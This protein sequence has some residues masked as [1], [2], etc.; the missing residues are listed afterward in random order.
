MDVV[1]LMRILFF[2]LFLF[3]SNVNAQIHGKISGEDGLALPYANVLIDHTT[4]GTVSNSE[5]YYYLDLPPGKY[6]L[7]F[8]YIGYKS[9]FREVLMTGQQL[10]LDVILLQESITLDEVTIRA[11]AEDPA[12]AII[13]NAI[14]ARSFNAAGLQ[15]FKGDLYMKG[16]VKMLDAP[17]SFMGIKIG[18]MEGLLDSTRSGIVYLSESESDVY[19]QAPDK[20]KEI[21]KSGVVAGEDNGFSFNQYGSVRFDFYRQHL[22]FERS[23]MTPLHD[24]ALSHYR[25]Q[26]MGT[27]YDEKGRQINKIAV[28]PINDAAGLFSGY[29]YIM[30]DS[31]RIYSLDLR[32]SGKAMKNRVFDFIRIRQIMNEDES[33]GIWY[34]QSQIVDFEAGFFSFRVGGT[35]SFFFREISLNIELPPSTFTREVFSM[36]N[37]AMKLSLTYWDSIRPIPLTHEEKKDYS[38]KDSLKVLKSSRQYMDSVDRANNHWKWSSL[39][40]GYSHHTTYKSRIIRMASPVSSLRFNAVEGWALG[41]RFTY[42]QFLREDSHRIQLSGLWRYGFTDRRWKYRIDGNYLIDRKSL[43]WITTGWGRDYFQFDERGLMPLV[44]NTISS[45][46]YKRNFVKLFDK[47]YAFAGVQ[48]ELWNGLYAWTKLSVEDRYPLENNTEWSFFR[49]DR[50]YESNHPVIPISELPV[51]HSHQAYLLDINFRWRPGQKYMSFPGFRVRMES[52][53]PEFF[54]NY[55]KA[56]PLS[57]NSMDYDRI[58]FRLRHR[59]IN[60]KTWGYSTLNFETG[61]FINNRQYEFPD[62]FHFIGGESFL[63]FH[64]RYI[65]GFK[66]MPF[67]QFS[68]DQSY[69]SFVFE[70]HFDGFILDKIPGLKNSGLKTVVGT[71][72]LLTWEKQYYEVSLGFENVGIGPLAMFRLDYGVGFGPNGSIFHG[73]RLGLSRSLSN[74]ID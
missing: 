37:D 21:M 47:K 2:L 41:S 42:T 64:D 33:S 50:R 59:N 6:T 67:Y 38:R 55:T 31:W 4:K 18:D 52:T 8:R 60:W 39:I 29:L 22:Q 20:L 72:M 25:F 69:L 28:M 61:T 46:L 3:N 54:V 32:F 58:L 30:E 15:S 74:I 9:E 71:G 35:F 70:H 34:K 14:R 11:D 62:Y 63:N 10:D 44:A 23:M 5:G 24:K 27:V 12:Y 7:E 1:P 66:V 45:T 49:K 40:F 73:P 16:M 26:W 53:W 68:T 51:F 43:V 57:N 56:L 19:Y 36:E 13:R 48:G 65:F 17:E